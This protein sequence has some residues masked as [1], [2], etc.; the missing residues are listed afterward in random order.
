M[1]SCSNQ[2]AAVVPAEAACLWH[3]RVAQVEPIQ[4]RNHK[5][6]Q[7]LSLRVGTS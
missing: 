2:T 6:E 7:H 3:R 4:R 5:R 1:A